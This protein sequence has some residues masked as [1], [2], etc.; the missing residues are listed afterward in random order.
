MD[1]GNEEL[2]VTADCPAGAENENTAAAELGKFKS[3]EA[4]LNAYRALEAEFTRRNQRLKE[5]ENENKAR[6]KDVSGAPS[7]E[8]GNTESPA[9]VQL[10]ENVKRAVIEDYLK[11][12]SSN[13]VQL[14]SGGVASAA[15]R[16]TLKS[17]KEAGE[18]AQRYLKK[19]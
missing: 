9:A 5:L 13:G 6:E 1:N 8:S 12:V 10:D 11:S 16:S 15:P 14:I 18:L 3:V 2:K 17:V 4:L 19:D 7:C